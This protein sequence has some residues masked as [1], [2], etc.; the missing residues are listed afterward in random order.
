MGIG[1]YDS[2]EDTMRYQESVEIYQ[3]GRA[4]YEAEARASGLKEGLHKGLAPLLRQ[5]QRKLGRE[6]T[7]ADQETLLTRLSTV[8]ADRFG[9]VVL[10][11]GGPALDRW[12]R[13]PN[14]T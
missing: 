4:E 6:L 14:A 9:D 2:Q 8:G 11:L 3:R 7:A 10:D 13:D 12:L 5:C 1:E